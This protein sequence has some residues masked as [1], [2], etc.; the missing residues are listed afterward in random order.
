MALPSPRRA[1]S[2]GGGPGGA[3]RGLVVALAVELPTIDLR[4]MPSA[5]VE[6]EVVEVFWK[7]FRERYEAEIERGI[8]G[9]FLVPGDL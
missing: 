9:I 4:A 6:D 7:A 1:L 2:A 3:P 5:T 8:D